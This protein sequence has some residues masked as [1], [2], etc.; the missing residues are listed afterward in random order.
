MLI[1]RISKFLSAYAII[2]LALAANLFANENEVQEQDYFQANPIIAEINGKIIRFEDLRDKA[3]QDAAQALYN[4]LARLLPN[5]VLNELAKSDAEIDPNPQFTISEDM[6]TLFY[7]QNRLENRGSIEDLR[8]QIRDYLANQLKQE[9]VYRQYNEALTKGLVKSYLQAPSEFLLETNVG[10]GYIRGNKEAKVIVLEYSDYQCPFCARVQPTLT[11]LIKEYGSRVAFGYR[12]FP[13]PFHKEA[14]EAAIAVECARD[15]GKFETLHALLFK[16]Q[17]N[18]F[19]ED[20][21]GY[22]DEIGLENVDQYEKCI[23]EE[24]YRSRVLEDMKAGQEAGVTGTPGFLIGTFNPKSG[25]VRGEL[26]SGARPLQDF[27]EALE[28]YLDRQS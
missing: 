28:K 24:K 27:K 6:V 10:Q 3:A 20:L 16:N 5:L 17:K 22:A 12:H 14:D 15:Q 25:R 19:V 4:Q 1:I 9:S 18:Q 21:I 13:L 11:E 26:L 7:K 23:V 2:L 8:P